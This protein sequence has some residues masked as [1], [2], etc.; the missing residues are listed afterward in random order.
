MAVTANVGQRLE[1]QPLQ[2]DSS[3][4]E[5]DRIGTARGTAANVVVSNVCFMTNEE[6]A[7]LNPEEAALSEGED[8]LYKLN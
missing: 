5:R 6:Y 2:D 7:R 1:S 3:I 4:P 8:D